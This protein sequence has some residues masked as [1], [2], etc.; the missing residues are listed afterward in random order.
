MSIYMLDH[1]MGSL[2]SNAPAVVRPTEDLVHC[3]APRREFPRLVDPGSERQ[4]GGGG[5]DDLVE[6]L[7]NTSQS[8]Q[9]NNTLSLSLANVWTQ[10]CFFLL[11]PLHIHYICA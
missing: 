11:Y 5:V 9:S 10:N 1:K 7:F 2:D 8:R 4:F 6:T 3:T